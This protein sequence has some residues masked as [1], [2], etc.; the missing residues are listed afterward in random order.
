MTPHEFIAALSWRDALDF[1]LLLIIVYTVLRLL[2][3]TRAL[4]VLLSVAV[5]SGLAAAAG[6]LD[7]V[8]VAPLLKVFLE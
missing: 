1:G 5:F 8:A 7:L 4:P 6:A 3:G 2:T